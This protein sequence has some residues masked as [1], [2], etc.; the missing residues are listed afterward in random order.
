ML[1]R[2]RLLLSTSMLLLVFVA[3]FL[4]GTCMCWRRSVLG[5]YLSILAGVL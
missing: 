1:C 4:L 3:G 2:R 5:L